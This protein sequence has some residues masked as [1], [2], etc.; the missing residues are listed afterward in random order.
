MNRFLL[1]KQIL[2][3]AFIF[4]CFPSD[5]FS[6]D[7]EAVERVVFVRG[8]N[9]WIANA[10]GT[11]ESQLTFSGQDRDPVLS[12]DEK[13]ITYTSDN[14]ELTGFGY[15]Y[16]IFTSGG[17]PN[18]LELKGMTGAEHA[19]FSPDGKSLI[20]VG[21][22]D[23][24]VKKKEGY[25]MTFA[26][27]SISIVELNSGKIKKIVSTPD[28]FLDAGYGY[29]NPSFSPDGKLIAYQHSGSDVS[30]GFSVIDLKGKTLFHFP[31]KSTDSTPHWRPLFTS[32]GKK[33]LCYSPATN[34]KETDAIYLIDLSSG[35]KKKITE[36]T[37]PAFIDNG[38]AIIFERWVNKWNPEG[39]ARSDVWY[40]ELREGS[41]PRKIIQNASHPSG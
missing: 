3:I 20:F 2:I 15:I 23:V 19:R 18:K 26:T 28:V 4:F 40:L 41:K 30:G 29:S 6:S 7:R 5:V 36:G 1:I 13:S 39:G 11:Q 37:N 12:P 25:D 33:F 34:E 35:A 8:G 27:M 38:K 32:D 10:D 17:K 9:I 24:K 22:S 21:M 16:S 31:N 14:D